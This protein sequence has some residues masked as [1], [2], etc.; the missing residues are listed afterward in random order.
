MYHCH[1]QHRPPA[2]YW[3]FRKWSLQWCQWHWVWSMQVYKLQGFKVLLSFCGNE[4]RMPILSKNYKINVQN[5][6]LKIKLLFSFVLLLVMYKCCFICAVLDFFD[7]KQLLPL[8]SKPC[9]KTMSLHHKP[10]FVLLLKTENN[11]PWL[12]TLAFVLCMSGLK[13]CLWGCNKHGNFWTGLEAVAHNW[14]LQLSMGQDSYP[15]TWQLLSSLSLWICENINQ[16][17]WR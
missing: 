15:H 3:L 7:L 16:L 8:P 5:T 14:Y 11:E 17:V 9:I 1:Q 10:Y 4:T 2:V 6:K 13:S 12:R